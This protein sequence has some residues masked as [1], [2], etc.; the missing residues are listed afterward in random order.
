MDYMV[1]PGLYFLCFST[2]W[3]ALLY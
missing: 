2:T 3:T 1:A